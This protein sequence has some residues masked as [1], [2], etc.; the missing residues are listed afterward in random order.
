MAF[1][2]RARREKRRRRRAI[3]GLYR[4]YELTYT[5]PDERDVIRPRTNFRREQIYLYRTTATPA[6]ARERFHEYLRSLNAI[7]ERPRLYNAITTNC[8]T[9]IRD[10]Q[11]AAERTPWDWRRVVG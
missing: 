7:R 11:P 5:V 9:S 3:G 1:S 2:K 6:Q 10:Q 4:Q 8:T